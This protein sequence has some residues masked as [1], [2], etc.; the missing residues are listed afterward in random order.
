L[1]LPLNA[2]GPR[3]TNSSHS[4][5]NREWRGWAQSRHG[6]EELLHVR[7]RRVS[8]KRLVLTPLIGELASIA[9]A[10]LSDILYDNVD[11]LGPLAEHVDGA[12]VKRRTI[13]A[14]CSRWIAGVTSR[15]R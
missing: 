13:S 14:F 3:S 4:G 2:D 10:V 11:V 12:C 9:P 6:P 5:I 7:Q 8:S 1:T 15:R